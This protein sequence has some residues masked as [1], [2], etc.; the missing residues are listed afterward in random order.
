MIVKC[1]SE[2]ECFGMKHYRL[3]S[4]VKVKCFGMNKIF[5]V[6]MKNTFS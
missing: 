2:M 3:I 4:T 1:L 6:K 5:A